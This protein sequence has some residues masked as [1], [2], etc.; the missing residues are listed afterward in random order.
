M[1]FIDY[2]TDLKE[3]SRKL[4]KFSTTAEILLWQQLKAGRMHGY[5]FNRQK[6]LGRYIV[7]FYCHKLKLVIEI[8]GHSHLTDHAVVNDIIR[9]KVLE[10]QGLYFMRY[11][12]LDVKQKMPL[13]LLSIE[14]TV[15]S[16]I[17]EIPLS[18]SDKSES[19]FPPL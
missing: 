4:R 9:Q 10:E 3:F 13:V 1:Y 12:D 8:D 11:D 2:N 16:R 5:T 14:S 6:P 18:D 7:D 15:L 17:K 19:D